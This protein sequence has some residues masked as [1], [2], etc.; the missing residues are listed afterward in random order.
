MLAAI[1]PN[2]C[3]TYQSIVLNI[4]LQLREAIT[5][6][7]NLMSPSMAY[8]KKLLKNLKKNVPIKK[9]LGVSTREA[10]VSHLKL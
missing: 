1:W 2:L 4:K 10:T 9:R 3:P 7:S 6:R 5:P 8:R